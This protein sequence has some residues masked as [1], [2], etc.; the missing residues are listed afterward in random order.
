MSKK[1]KK[2]EPSKSEQAP[3][4][5]TSSGR[6]LPTLFDVSFSISKLVV[7]LIGALTAVISVTSGATALNAALRGCLA[8][9]CIGLTLWM[10]NWIMVR[11]SLAGVL[12]KVKK[13]KIQT[14]NG[15]SRESTFE[16]NA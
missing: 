12:V 9:F 10:L 16:K 8:M 6:A 13:L 11:E 3:R 14:A 15:M 7:L 2:A 5:K 1:E 4:K